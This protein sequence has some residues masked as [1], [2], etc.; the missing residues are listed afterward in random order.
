[1]NSQFNISVTFPDHPKTH[2]LIRRLGEIAALC[3]VWLWAW[4]A[5]NRPTGL[6]EGMDSEDTAIAARWVGD[7]DEFVDTLV[8]L[9]WLDKEGDV[10]VVHGWSER[11]KF[12]SE[13]GE[14]SLKASYLGYLK[15]K[16]YPKAK[17]VW[18]ANPWLADHMRPGHLKQCDKHA[19]PEQ[20]A[21]QE[22]CGTHSEVHADGSAILFSSL[23]DSSL[24][25]PK[26]TCG[27]PQ[28]GSP[29]ADDAIMEF[30]VRGGGTW[31]LT[32][33]VIAGWKD[34]YPDV[35]VLQQCKAALE[36]LKANPART[37]KNIRSFLTGWLNRDQGQS[38]KPDYNAIDRLFDECETAG[39]DE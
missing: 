25:H 22:A 37:K 13:A 5:A 6:L 27:E 16:N 19:E 32:Q 38:H 14:R 34:A 31:L 23:L 10:L 20:A 28:D 15:N 36:W 12:A 35:D 8:E 39:G 2:K 33:S 7:A 30:P 18:E 11:N 24:N 26:D 21:M 17:E 3:L 4:V 1:M 29:L 9:R